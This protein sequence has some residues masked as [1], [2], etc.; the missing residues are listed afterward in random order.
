MWQNASHL[1]A[2]RTRTSQR[3]LRFLLFILVRLG[4]NSKPFVLHFQPCLQSYRSPVAFSCIVVS[5]TRCSFFQWGV[6]RFSIIYC[7]TRIRDQ[8][9]RINFHPSKLVSICVFYDLHLA[10][11]WWLTWLLGSKSIVQQ[12]LVVVL[13]TVQG[14]RGFWELFVNNMYEFKILL[15]VIVTWLQFLLTALTGHLGEIT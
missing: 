6:I 11:K 8:L 7:Y 4:W 3:C 1:H 9:L 15:M 14:Y 13:M 2:C 10:S 5:K 12:V